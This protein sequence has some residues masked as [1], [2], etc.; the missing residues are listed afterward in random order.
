VEEVEGVVSGKLPD[1]L[2]GSL[3]VNG[4]GDYT[5]MVHMFDGLA[6]LVKLRVEG[7][8]VWASQRYV[9]TE[10][11][12]HYKRTGRLR[13]REFG[14]P[15]PAAN[16]GEKAGQVAEQLLALATK[17]GGFTDNASVSVTP[18]PDGS[19][20]AGSETA[21]SVY[22]VDPQRLATLNQCRFTGDGVPG[23][24]LTAHPKLLPGGVSMVNFSR[25]LPLGG[26]HVY[27]QDMRTLKRRQVAYIPDRDPLNPAWVHD[28]AVTGRHAVIFEM[29]LLFNMPALMLGENN[30]DHLFMDWKPELGTRIHV[31]ALDGSGVKSYNAPPFFTFHF[32]NGFEEGGALHVDF[33][34]YADARIMDDLNMGPIFQFPGKEVSRSALQRV[35]I[36]LDAPS[37]ATLPGPC[38]VLKDDAAYGNFCEFPQ[39]APNAR[40]RPY[41]YTYCQAARRPTN[42]GNALAKHDVVAGTSQLW[43]QDGCMPGEAAFVPRPGGTAEDDGV[44][45]APVMGADGRSFLLVLDAARWTEVARAALPYGAPYRFHGTWLPKTA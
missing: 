20:L 39:V 1:W 7:G 31:V 9:A 42:L 23:D 8:R 18:L 40:Y 28:F 29:P 38:S 19:V 5:N 45:V 34:G 14:T 35:T 36:P 2:Q 27:V 33:A 3:L 12:K 26:F 32:A 30:R 17:V 44:V 10:Q 11:Y 15:L 41:R 16:V 6:M 13:W 22:R 25:V 37:G 43:H 24:L 4:G 21:F